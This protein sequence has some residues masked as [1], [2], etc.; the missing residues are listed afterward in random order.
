MLRLGSTCPPF[1]GTAAYY[2]ILGYGLSYMPAGVFIIG[3]DSICHATVPAT[4]MVQ[5]LSWKAGWGVVAHMNLTETLTRGDHVVR[6]SW[7][8]RHGDRTL[9]QK[10]S[11]IECS[12]PIQRPSFCF[13]PSLVLQQRAQRHTAVSGPNETINH[14]NR[15]FA[16]QLPSSVFALCC[17]LGSGFTF[18]CSLP[19]PESIVNAPSERRCIESSCSGDGFGRACPVLEAAQRILLISTGALQN[20][21]RR[22]MRAEPLPAKDASLCLS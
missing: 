7:H 13:V 22:P 5:L 21:F 1:G 18:P 9:H 12:T 20:F 14:E 6:R 17:N 8:A 11:S 15:G 16:M 19:L 2:R 10:V 3:P 4:S